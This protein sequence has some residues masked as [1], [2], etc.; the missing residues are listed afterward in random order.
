MCASPWWEDTSIPDKLSL[1]KL[2]SQQ[3]LVWQ[4]ARSKQIVWRQFITCF[5]CW[6]NDKETSMCLFWSLSPTWN[7]SNKKCSKK[8]ED[9]NNTN[10]KLYLYSGLK[11][12]FRTCILYMC[13]YKWNKTFERFEKQ[14]FLPLMGP[15]VK[16]GFHAFILKTITPCPVRQGFGNTLITETDMWLFR[17]E[18]VR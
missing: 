15:S 6:L 8:L 12:H 13:S 5:I 2:F 11:S 7:I 17:W 4:L 9:F 18:S 1:L 10:N 14:L 3:I 16:N